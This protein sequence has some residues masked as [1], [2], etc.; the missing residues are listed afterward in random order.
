MLTSRIR[1][2]ES[3]SDWKS[4]ALNELQYEREL[5]E[6]PLTDLQENVKLQQ[7]WLKYAS[8][9]LYYV[10]SVINIIALIFETEVARAASFVLTDWEK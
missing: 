4:L 2:K 8:V 6:E 3:I 7:P 9:N 5:L 10:A 1:S